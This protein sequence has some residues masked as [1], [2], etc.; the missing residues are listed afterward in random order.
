MQ[1]MAWYFKR[2]SLPQDQI[3]FL[4]LITHL[5]WLDYWQSNQALMP[6]VA[7]DLTLNL[8]G[9]QFQMW[10]NKRI[11]LGISA[12][13]FYDSPLWRDKRKRRNWTQGKEEGGH[14]DTHPQRLKAT[15]LWSQVPKEWV[16][17][18]PSSSSSLSRW[19]SFTAFWTDQKLKEWH[20]TFCSDSIPLISDKTTNAY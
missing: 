9:P 18:K 2:P 4:I 5:I 10:K 6:D 15:I 19:S 7:C 3:I 12:Q 1:I 11:S 17:L 8:S 20:L 14:L 13:I 16:Q